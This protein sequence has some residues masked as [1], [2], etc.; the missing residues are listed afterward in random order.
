MHQR[1]NKALS[2][3]DDSHVVWRKVG[4]E[5]IKDKNKALSW[6]DDSHVVWR[7]VGVECIK[8]KIKRYLGLM[9]R[10]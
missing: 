7:K 6:T 5:C 3:T 2:W 8:D 4:V 1:Q 10:M 9:T